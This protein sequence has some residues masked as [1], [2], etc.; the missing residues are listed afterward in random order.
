MI[1][2]GTPNWSQDVD[3]IST[4]LSDKWDN[5]MYTMHFYAGTHK[6]SYIDKL[7]KAEIAKVPVF[8]SEF[9]ICDASGSGSI[10]K[11][12][13]NKWIK[14]LDEYNISY[15]IW[16][17]SNKNETSALIKSGV[18]KTHGFTRKDLSPSGKWFWGHFT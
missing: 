15:C 1:L 17:L 5:I 6:E 18:S 4:E 14:I 11:K 10:D 7:K 13:A 8:I 9:G 2:V 12:S 16:N 3:L